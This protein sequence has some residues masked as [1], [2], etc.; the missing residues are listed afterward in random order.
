MSH[1]RVAFQCPLPHDSTERITLAHG[2]GGRLSRRLIEDRIVPILDPDRIHE[3]SDAFLLP[4]TRKRLAFTTD[5]FVVSPLFF[6]GGDIGSV[7]VNGT[8]NDLAV[9]GARPRWISLSL[10]IEEGFAWPTLEAVLRSVATAASSAGVKVVTG[11][12]KV[13]NRGAADGLFLNTTGIGEL[14]E[15]V[16]PGPLA[17]VPGD[18][19]LVSGPIGKHGIAVMSAREQLD[20]DPQP[21]SDCAPLHSVV[22]ALIAAKIPVKA[23]RDATRGGVAAVMHEWAGAS[24]HSL[25]ITADTLPVTAEVRG[26]CELLGLNPLHVANEGTMVVAV[27]ASAVDAALHAMQ[28]IPQAAQTMLIGE[29]VPREIVS[30]VLRQLTGVDV[31]LDEPLGSPLPRIC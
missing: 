16:P 9:A 29:V 20:F 4:T 8:V 1:E 5:S 26:A 28:S 18:R 25:R 27:P 17:L 14:F 11:D 10:I 12:T 3:L 22:E 7:A 2:E 15:N 6:P 30:V 21:T 19:L 24:Q 23:M 13:V 31:P